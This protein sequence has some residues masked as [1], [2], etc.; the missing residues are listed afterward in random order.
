[1]ENQVKIIIVGESFVGKTCIVNRF[2]QSVFSNQVSPTSSVGFS[3]KQFKVNNSDKTINVQIWDTAGSEKFRALNKIYIKSA[4]AAIIVYDITSK[5][6]F[7]ELDYWIKQIKEICIN[8]V[9]ISIAANKSDLIQQ[10]EV[11]HSEGEEYAKKSNAI[12]Y[13]TSAKENI[14]IDNLF[15]SIG[16]QFL[17]GNRSS[18]KSQNSGIKLGSK[19]E[20]KLG[21]NNKKS[22]C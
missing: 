4:D 16:E 5:K 3:S 7:E 2:I 20:E 14:G 19:T 13:A 1:M 21:G 9:I 8:K 6:S 17:R 22:C 11:T 12:F 18:R 15:Q 10:A